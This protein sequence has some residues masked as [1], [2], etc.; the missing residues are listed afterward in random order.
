MNDEE[1]KS[2]TIRIKPSILQEA[3]KRAKREGKTVGRWIEDAIVE[4]IERTKED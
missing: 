4:K 3:H 1:R 2:R